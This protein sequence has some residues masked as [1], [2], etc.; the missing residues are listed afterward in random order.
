MTLAQDGKRMQREKQVFLEFYEGLLGSDESSLPVAVRNRLVEDVGWH[1]PCPIDSAEGIEAFLQ[2]VWSPMAGAFDGLSRRDDILMSGDYRQQTWVAA[3]GYYHGTFRNDWLSIPATNKPASLR[4]GE[5]ARVRD[6]RICEFRVLFDL[7]DFCRQA[8]IE[9]LPPD[10]GSSGPVPPP[11]SADGVMLT[12]PGKEEGQRSLELVERMIEGL[13]TYDG[14]DLDSMAMDRF[15]A[16]DMRWYGPGGIGTTYG[17]DGFQAQHQ[18]PF[19]E[20]FPDRYA[21]PHAA[22]LAEGDYVC[23]T[24]WPSVIGTHRGEYLGLPATGLRVGM[25][26]MDF[27]RREGD[28]LA[29]NWVLIDMLDLF[30]QLGVDL[31]RNGLEAHRSQTSNA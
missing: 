7:V 28:W 12:A 27:W 4:F 31:L 20:A 21:G 5:F 29:E 26:V 17:L 1:G 8:G 2:T 23:V 18:G 30:R 22:L 16:P 19:L 13:L 24:G 3:T 11:A 6:G 14:R 10:A 25:R 9:L 15:W